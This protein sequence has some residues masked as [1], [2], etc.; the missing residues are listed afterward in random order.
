MLSAL[1]AH[2]K[3]KVIALY[4]NRREGPF[5]CPGCRDEVILH[6]GR[7]RIHHFQHRPHARCARAHP[8]GQALLMRCKLALYQSLKA[9]QRV[10]EVD[11]EKDFGDCVADVYARIGRVPVAIHLQNEDVD[12]ASVDAIMRAHL[13][14]GVAVLWVGVPDKALSTRRAYAPRDWERWCHA[15]YFGRVYHWA[16]AGELKSFH[17]AD[18]YP[19]PQQG[20]PAGGTR[21]RSP[22]M[23]YKT[24]LSGPVVGISDDFRA[25]YRKPLNAKT[26]TIPKCRIYIDKRQPWWT[27]R[28]RNS[29]HL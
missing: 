18:Y 6:K 12:V 7:V 20:A 3:D 22:S 9:S 13:K 24:P 4:C 11:I 16:G 10:S 25:L 21:H 27:G 26:I 28:G 19:P 14:R 2:T 15:A 1:S 8:P 29:T 17:F 23:H 5:I